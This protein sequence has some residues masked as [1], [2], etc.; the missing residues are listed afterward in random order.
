MVYNIY[1]DEPYLEHV[2]QPRRSGRYPWGSGEDPYQS[3]D[4]FVTTARRLSNEG[5]SEKDIAEWFGFE[6]TT[7]LRDFKS[8]AGTRLKQMDV[9]RVQGYKDRGWSNTKIAEKTG[10]SEPQVRA[11]LKPGADKKAKQLADTSNTLKA[12][13]DEKTYLDVG[14]GTESAMGVSTGVK[15]KA[16]RS[17]KMDGYQTHN[18]KVPQ[19]GTGEMTNTL[20]LVPPGITWNDVRQNIA[21]IAAFSGS[22]IENAKNTLTGWVRP[23]RIETNRVEVKFGD[24]EGGEKEDG[25]IH[26]RRGVDDVSLGENHYA[27]VRVRVGDKHYLKGM[28]VY[29]DDMP[30]G[31]DLVFNTNKPRSVGKLGAMKE[32]KTL[33]DGKVDWDNPFGA[34]IKE[35]MQ[36]GGKATS[37]MNIVNDDEGWDSWS[38]NLSSQF[39]SKQSIPL[40]KTQL[41]LSR[42]ERNAEFEEIKS[43]TNPT[44]KRDLLLKFADAT[45]ASAEHLQAAHLPRQKTHVIMPVNS[46][47]DNEVYAPNFK[48]GERLVLIR[49]PHGGKF[50]IPELTVN[51]RN[52]EGRSL[53][54]EQ[55]RT[56]LGINS[57]VAERLSGADFDGDTVVAIP[58]NSGRVHSQSPLKGLENFQPDVQYGLPVG[59]SKADAP[60]RTMKK[61]EIGMEMGR[62]S[63]LITDMSVKGANDDELARAVRHSMVVIDA[64]KH[65]Y[66]YKQSEQDNRIADLRK[67]Y[68]E[69]SRSPTGGADT[70]ISKASSEV[71][72]D[73]RRDARTSEGGPID[74]ETGARRYVE[75]G[76]KYRVLNEDG[77]WVEGD[78]PRQTK[79]TRMDITEDAHT[80]SSGSPMEAVYADHANSMKS[81]ANEARLEY[82]RTPKQTYS[83]EAFDTYRTEVDSLDSKLRV[84]QA[85]APKERSAQRLAGVMVSQKKNDNPHLDKNDLKKVRSQSLELARQR[86]GANKNRVEPTQEEWNAIQEGAVTNY[87]LEQILT[88][89]NPD[90]IR[91]LATPRKT[92]EVSTPQLSMISALAASGYTQAEIAER[93]GVSTSTVSK[94]I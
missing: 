23:K 35:Q 62:I 63:N 20:V 30:D 7:E 50:E 65:G 54:G 29:K 36:E 1:E 41:E 55:P 42:A 31:V 89:S 77:K 80:L 68:Q 51:N 60:F 47:K 8:I 57:D 82:T 75:T 16:V 48:N 46:L 84:A 25:V 79:T 19:V 91:E 78:K 40:A 39:L 92:T 2:G 74:L 11:L 81:L 59:V 43:L 6:N 34:T 26:V 66:D 17:L 38:K 37:V 69:G 86:T 5:M 76:K 21:K 70:L 83:S 90:R 72:V 85:N 64:E 93:L 32:M 27:Q 9:H 45:D 10:I 22:V 12:Q 49:Y 56:A 14:H 3:M 71:R 28:A 58:N 44:V 33:A 94:H 18:I 87:K 61:S 15:E 13:V 73:E 88:N 53:L 24:G 67:R 52:K 4:K